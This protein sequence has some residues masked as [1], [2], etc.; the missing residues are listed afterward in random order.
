MEILEEFTKELNKESSD[1]DYVD[2]RIVN[3]AFRNTKF[4]KLDI[5]DKFEAIM[6]DEGFVESMV[7]NLEF[8][9]QDFFNE[10]EQ[11]KSKNKHV[12]S[13]YYCD[14]YMKM[15][16]AIAKT[17][18]KW[19]EE[20]EIYGNGLDQLSIPIWGY[21]IR[22]DS[23]TFD[24][25]ALEMNHNNYIRSWSAYYGTMDSFKE[26]LSS[27]NDIKLID[28]IFSIS[29]DIL[30]SIEERLNDR[31]NADSLPAEDKK[32]KRKRFMRETFK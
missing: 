28:N 9:Q 13:R 29:L 15:A 2:W 11:I 3:R 24:A 14:A 30:Q 27:K 32:L 22:F 26:N 6:C 4:I 12:P 20:E 23:N 1:A 8:S 19:N 25:E 16:I 18:G 17:L 10:Q 7:V 21:A 31:K 5:L